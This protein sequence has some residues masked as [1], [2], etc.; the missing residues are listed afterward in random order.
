MKKVLA[1][2]LAVMMMATVAFA[3][4]TPNTSADDVVDKENTILFGGYMAPGDT[5][6]V[7]RGMD[8]GDEVNGNPVTPTN[9]FN[10]QITSENYTITNQK[11][12][13]G[14]SLLSGLVFD[15]KNN[16]LK[17]NLVED[18]T[19]KQSKRLAGSFT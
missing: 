10:A 9:T 6:Y 2:V 15:D 17:I 16:Q 3:T 11:W 13:E 12:T 7:Y 19:L 14:K 4:T 1:L 5:L 18:Y 8:S